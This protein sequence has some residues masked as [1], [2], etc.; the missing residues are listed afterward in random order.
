MNVMILAAGMGTRLHPLTEICPK[1]LVPLMLQP[2]L[3]HLLTQLR[4]YHVEEVVINLHHHAEQLRQWIG[5]GQQ[6]GFRQIHLS[7]EPEILGTAGA[8]KNAETVLGDAPFCVINAD[9]LSDIDLA[10]VWQWHCQRNAVVTMVLRPDPDAHRY[11]PVVVDGDHRVCH[12]NGRPEAKSH[13]TG[14]MLMFTGMQ[15]VSPQ[16]FDAIAPNQC[17][18][19]AAESYPQLIADGAAVYGY[20]Y[21]GY[22]MDVGVPTR[23]R[24]AYW[25]V[26]DGV[27]RSELA[28]VPQGTRIISRAEE[29]PAAWAHAT[30]HP[31]VVVGANVELAP[32]A[33]IGPYAV[34][35]PECRLETG[36]QVRESV[37]WDGVRVASHAE[38]DRS[39]LG[40]DVVVPAHQVVSDAVQSTASEARA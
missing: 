3:G 39:I 40:T 25:D 28:L 33:C 34:L 32:N 21:D 10:A 24:Q 5:N 16:I 30:I 23:Y 19:T 14:D 37:L 22:W 27:I 7:Y 8:I 12:I 26:L 1:P 31:P 4:Q 17:L 6:W 9:V 11:G 13:L 15:V 2:M 35:G 38:V 29:T 20:R 36:A 18:S